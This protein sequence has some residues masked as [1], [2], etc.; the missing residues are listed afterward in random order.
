[1]WTRRYTGLEIALLP[2]ET[3]VFYVLLRG[4]GAA[5][6]DPPAA[7]PVDSL[8]AARGVALEWIWVTHDDWDHSGG[9]DPLIGRWTPRVARGM[10][11]GA[12]VVWRELEIRAIDTPGHRRRHTAFYLPMPEPG[13]LFSGD[14]LFAGG[15]GRLNGLPPELMFASLRRLAA[16]PPAT[17][18]FCGHDYLDENLRFALTVEPENAAIR[19]RIARVERLRR[20][21]AA[22]L[23]STLAEELETNPFLRARD[24]A[25]FAARRRAKDCF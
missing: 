18:I 13:L 9:V 4:N 20:A 17:E 23:P 1:M 15:C 12:S 19:E 3:N 8:L 14:C 5:A 6:V 11:D 24:V 2:W 7:A 22:A 16:L 25:E 10:P 21:G